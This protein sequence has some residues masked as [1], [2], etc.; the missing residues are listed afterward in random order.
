MRHAMLALLLVAVLATA[1]GAGTTKWTGSGEFTQDM[2]VGDDLTVA[3]DAAI[4][5]DAEVTGATSCKGDVTLGD[6]SADSLT[7]TATYAVTKSIWFPA[8]VFKLPSSAPATYTE[9]CSMGALSFADSSADAH[10]WL[11]FVPPDDCDESEDM[12]LFYYYTPADAAT[13]TEGKW[14]CKVKGMGDGDAVAA[15]TTALEIV[16]DTPQSGGKVNITTGATIPAA[17]IVEN[18]LVNLLVYHDVADPFGNAALLLG[19]R[20]DYVSDKP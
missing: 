15:A 2:T 17:N 10:A 13:N 16:Y 9:T 3:D 20:I 5:G 14:N 19:V 18:E 11:V 6:A 1:A 4:G 8:E 12:E 7:V